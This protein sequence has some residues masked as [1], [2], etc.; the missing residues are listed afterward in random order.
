MDDYF[1]SSKQSLSFSQNA[2]KKV[3]TELLQLQYFTIL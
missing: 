2:N 1:C 3:I